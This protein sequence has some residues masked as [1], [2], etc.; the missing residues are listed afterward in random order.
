MRKAVAE[1]A[2]NFDQNSRLSLVKSTSTLFSKARNLAAAV[3]LIFAAGS[4]HAQ[5]CAPVFNTGCAQDDDIHTFTL[6]GANGSSIIDSNTGCSANN[7]RNATNLSATM[8]QGGVYSAWVNTNYSDEGV[9]VYIDLNNDNTFSPNETVGGVNSVDDM[10]ATFQ[11]YIPANAQTGSHRMR[12]V[13]SYDF[14]YPSISACPTA[15]YY[16][17]GE[18]HDYTVTIIAGTGGPAC[19]APAAASASAMSSGGA[20]LWW[21]TVNG[22]IGYEYVI[23][24]SSSAPTGAGTFT[25]ANTHT[26]T[27]LSAGQQYHLH[28]RAKC[29]ATAFSP[30][31]TRPFVTGSVGATCTAPGGL[32]ATV[33][34]TQA[35]LSWS[36]PAGSLGYEIFL[37]D[38]PN[39]YPLQGTQWSGTAATYTGLDPYTPYYFYLRHEC[40]NQTVSDWAVLTLTS[41][42]PGLSQSISGNIYSDDFPFTSI[43]TYK[44]FLIR[45]DSAS[46]SLTAVDSLTTSGG[47]Y[48]FSGMNAGTYFVKAAQQTASPNTGGLGQVP[49]Y[50]DSTLY[51][52]TATPQLITAGSTLANRHIWMRMGTVTS[53]PGFIGGNVSLGANKGTTAGVPNL[54]IFLRNAAGKM[55]KATYTDAAG[56]FS[57]GSLPTGTYSVYPERMNYATTPFNAITI[58]TAQATRTG[59]NFNQDDGDETIA[60]R[61]TGIKAL[62]S[63]LAFE[64]S[65][66]PAKGA[67]NLRWAQRS[68]DELRISVTSAIGQVVRELRVPPGARETV[69][70]INGL[71]P[72]VYFVRMQQDAEIG[73]EKLVVE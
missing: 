61:T 51:W 9:Q 20:E 25:T 5:Y 58:T 34:G 19:T 66:N 57:F 50:H 28:V 65:P 6:A 67:V 59:I 21:S 45:Y 2:N 47:F 22:A 11:L 44:V 49:T 17:Y 35:T 13:L 71:Q 32:T 41:G 30:W 52:S 12:V 39:L 55:L 63:T 7:Y 4:A 54:L 36:A 40:S 56:N 60:P 38:V 69:I 68:G 23:N 46:T 18:V 72:G 53:G 1:C 3:S 64:L 43:D 24:Q 37:T 26:A 16:D 62:A 29:G 70:D 33:S 42:A 10:G 48:N 8:E 27:G 73:M 15:Q 14:Q 31:L